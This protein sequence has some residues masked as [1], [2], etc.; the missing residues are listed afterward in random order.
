MTAGT[1][2]ATGGVEYTTPTNLT[3]TFSDANLN[4]ATSDFSGTINW[5][6]GNPVTNFDS[7]DVT[8]Y[9]NGSFTVNAS[10][11][12]AE[13]GTYRITVTINDV[14]TSTTTDMGTTTVAD[15]PLTAGTVVATAVAS[16][17]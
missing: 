17:A 15:A 4:A 2:S 12:Y 14:G 6:D 9:G 3:A 1:V 11:Q 10:Y 13:E 16:R 7:S 5:G 8:A